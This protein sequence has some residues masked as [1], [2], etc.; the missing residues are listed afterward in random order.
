M[1]RPCFK[2]TAHQNNGYKYL[3]FTTKNGLVKKVAKEEF[4]ADTQNLNGVK[5]TTIKDDDHLV[6]INF[7]NDQNDL[8]LITKDG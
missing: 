3:L 2:K 8:I 6:S 5:A 1:Q 7:I 4:I